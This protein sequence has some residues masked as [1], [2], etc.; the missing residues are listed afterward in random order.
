MNLII[1]M[2]KYQMSGGSCRPG[3]MGP[4]SQGPVISPGS[5]E[6]RRTLFSP[7]LLV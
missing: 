6:A 4:V 7:A 5:F 1:N 2:K 3:A